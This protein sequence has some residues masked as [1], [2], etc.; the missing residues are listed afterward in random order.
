MVPFRF[1]SD[2]LLDP[3]MDPVL[4]FLYCVSKRSCPSL[5]IANCYTETGNTSWTYS[6]SD[7]LPEIV[8]K[9][10]KIWGK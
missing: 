10:F 1:E 5:K 9:E 2:P 4:N 7:I 3:I 8:Q 6:V